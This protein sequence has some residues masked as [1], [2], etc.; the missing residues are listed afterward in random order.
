MNF[1]K[2]F[3]LNTIG[4]VFFGYIFC[5]D[6][7]NQDAK[8][9]GGSEFK[10]ITNPDELK[11]FIMPEEEIKNRENEFIQ[12]KEFILLPENLKKLEGDFYISKQVIEER[13]N[14]SYKYYHAR[15]LKFLIEDGK[16]C[17]EK[18]FYKFAK[19]NNHLMASAQY[20]RKQ[21]VLLPLFGYNEEEIKDIEKFLNNVSNECDVF[22]IEK[23]FILEKEM[24]YLHSIFS[25]CAIQKIAIERK[26]PYAEQNISCNVLYK[27]LQEI[28][29]NKNYLNLFYQDENSTNQ[30]KPFTKRLEYMKNMYK[31]YLNTKKEEENTISDKDLWYAL[32]HIT[33]EEN[34]FLDLLN[35]YSKNLASYKEL[36]EAGNKIITKLKRFQRYT[37]RDENGKETTK[38]YYDETYIKGYENQLNET[39]KNAKKIKE[40]EQDF[41]F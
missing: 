32:S 15:H 21:K 4:I 25:S 41:K 29:L 2:I 13:L 39:L 22:Q 10:L 35:N 17:S 27:K 36:E 37:Y 3:L 16:I 1:K 34:Y 33:N 38:E 23:L 31:Q 18:E 8:Q 12:N 5:G 30:D 19:A 40:N 11:K 24:E 14:S 7:N 26:I 6:Q 28:A 9:T 20:I